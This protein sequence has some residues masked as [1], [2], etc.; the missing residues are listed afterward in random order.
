[1][2]LLKQELSQRARA[3][4]KR[5]VPGQDYWAEVSI[6]VG[7]VMAAIWYGG[8]DN[9]EYLS[10]W[11]DT[12]DGYLIALRQSDQRPPKDELFCPDLAHKCIQVLKKHMILEDLASI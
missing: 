6:R 8:T 12:G 4:L 11:L 2:P 1:M 5:D 9:A 3:L 10:V 7:E